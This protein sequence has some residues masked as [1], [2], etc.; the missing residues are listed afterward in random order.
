MTT[1]DGSSVIID[2]TAPFDMGSII[3]GYRIYI[4]EIDG[5]TYHQEYTHCD[6]TDSAVIAAQSCSVPV[7]TI[8]SSY[9]NLAWGTS[10]YAKV[11][12]YNV[13]GDSLI[14]DAGN[15]A[16]IMTVPDAPVSL[17]ENSLL[18]G[19]T[20]IGLTWTEGLSDGGSP[21]LD[22]NIHFDLGDGVYT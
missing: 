7:A 12:A 19:A 5:L 4:I 17:A 15:G 2:W 11:I 20:Q 6:G 8:M 18:R 3:S 21:V 16:V 13:Y 14:S 22:Y 10:V 1:F 9:F